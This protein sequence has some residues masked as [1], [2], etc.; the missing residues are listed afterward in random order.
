MNSVDRKITRLVALFRAPGFTNARRQALAIDYLDDHLEDIV[1]GV[2][3]V[4]GTY[5]EGAG[6]RG[7]AGCVTWLGCA[8][9]VLASGCLIN[10]GHSMR[11]AGRD[12][13]T[14]RYQYSPPRNI[15]DVF[16]SVP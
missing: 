10:L 2:L 13:I 4:G 8:G 7:V 9:S 16:C 14:D 1:G 3:V 11:A 6:I 12:L 15:F 5:I